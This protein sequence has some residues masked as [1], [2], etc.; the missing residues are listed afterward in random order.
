M[1]QIINNK[2]YDT[3]TADLLITWDNNRYSTAYDFCEE[4]L[5]RKKNGEFFLHIIAG[6]NS[7]HSEKVYSSCCREVKKIIKFTDNQAKDWLAIKRYAET[8]EK[9]FGEVEE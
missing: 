1:K 2:K 9:I 6:H 5:Y 4:K 7:K 3:E 8:Y